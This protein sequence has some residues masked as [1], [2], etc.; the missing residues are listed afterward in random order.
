MTNNYAFKSSFGYNSTIR[1]GRIYHFSSKDSL[2]YLL[3]VN[4]DLIEI[5]IS[6]KL[7]LRKYLRNYIIKKRFLKKIKLPS[8]LIKRELGIIN[9]SNIIKKIEYEMKKYN[10]NN[11]Y[12][13]VNQ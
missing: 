1:E 13:E 5:L 3:E 9:F 6:I 8:D 2:K 12:E 4:I 7:R 11:N 10:R